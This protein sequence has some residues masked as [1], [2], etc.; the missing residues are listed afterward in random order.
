MILMIPGLD[1]TK[2]ELRST[3]DLFLERGVATFS[4]DGPGQG[5]AEYR[6]PIRADWEVPAR[7]SSTG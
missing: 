4:V 3:E 5:E 1:S 2:E 6:L 7:P